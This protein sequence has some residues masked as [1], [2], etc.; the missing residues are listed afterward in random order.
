MVGVEGGWVWRGYWGGVGF[1]GG[2]EEERSEATC[3]QLVT[4][5]LNRFRNVHTSVIS[6]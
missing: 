2:A 4:I 6:L 3:F 1:E 5:N